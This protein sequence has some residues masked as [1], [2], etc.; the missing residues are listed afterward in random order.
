V[1]YGLCA[2]GWPVHDVIVVGTRV[3]GA[4]TAM[5]LARA[6]LRVLAVDRARFP[7]DTLS[8]HQ[9]QLPGVALLRRWGLLEAVVAS[10]TPAAS[11]IRLDVASEP[12]GGTTAGGVVLDGVLPS[13]DGADAIYSP[14]RTVLDAI[15]VDAARAAGAEVRH[16]YRMEEL[17]V[18]DH[19]RVSGIRG[20]QG[21]GQSIVDIAGLVVGADGKR[22]TVARAVGARRYRT[23]PPSTVACYG[24][25]SG[26]PLDHGELYQRPGL[27]AAAFPTNDGLT[28]V[29]LAAPVSELAA[30]RADPE[31]YYLAGLDRCGDLGERVR[32]GRRA[33]RLRIAPDLPSMFRVPHGPGWAL[34]GDAGLVM[35]PVSAQGIGNALRDAERLAAAI[36]RG[37]DG[38]TGRGEAVG[39]GGSAGR[40]GPV[41][42]QLAGA[43]R[44]RD[45]A[46]R[47]M[48]DLTTGLAALRGPGRAE[49]RVIEAVRGRPDEVTRFLGVFSGAEPVRGY[50]SVGNA[51]R[52]VGWAGLPGLAA[53]RLRDGL[54]DRLGDGRWDRLSARRRAPA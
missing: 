33:E 21:T 39:R 15:L 26:V 30:L 53:D 23:R 44:E 36:V 32:A 16:G 9:I 47:P 43:W 46:L 28:M 35:D 5:L 12:A 29:Y 20:R 41:A 22:S 14:R 34:V 10:G 8:T 1:V 31:G 11:R 2:R 52:L 4:A 18:D 24:Y 19:G 6:G 50:R 17:T 3:A 7:S 42:A 37:L 54:G 49:R 38:K 13:L 27:A 45:A 48:Y 25:W 51:L 40:G